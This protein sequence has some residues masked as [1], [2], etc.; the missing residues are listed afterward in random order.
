[1]VSTLTRVV[2]IAAAVG[3]FVA[4]RTDVEPMTQRPAAHVTDEA[5]DDADPT[6]PRSPGPQF[7]MTQIANN[8]YSFQSFGARNMVVVTTAG[9]IVTDP[10]NPVAAEQL[11]GEIEKITDQPVTLVIYSHNHWDHIAGAQIFT[12]QGATVLQHESSAQATRPNA[13]V[14]PAD[15]TFAG[16]RH[17][18]SLGGE[19]IELISV[20]PSH[21]TGMLV[22]L[23][24][25]HRILHTVDVVTPN[26]IAFRSMPDFTPQG[27]ILALEK[28][29]QLDFD[30]II[31]GHG[32]AEAPRSA[33]TE[34]REYIE[35]LS[36]AVADAT[37][38]TGNPFDFETM[39]EL[40]K[41]DLR[42]KYG[43]WEQFDEWM[44]LN[45]E[46]IVYEQNIGW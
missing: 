42:P 15:E 30:R 11:M 14:V 8:V 23:L 12:D 43:E 5:P 28:I 10:L 36:Q 31:P 6:D 33:V 39:T 29:E 2:S 13:A 26:R 40:V 27:W 34:Q 17:V 21:G 32:P 41:E 18:V 38:E 37:A 46:R 16:D 20:G 19:T 25:E 4:G 45:V 7:D 3:L 44:E 35:D 9:V 22:M 24:P 1:M